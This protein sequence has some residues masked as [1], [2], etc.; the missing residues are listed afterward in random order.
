MHDEPTGCGQVQLEP[1]GHALGRTEGS[2][3]DADGKDDGYFVGE[4]GGFPKGV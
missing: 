1:V 4:W 3:D 2:D